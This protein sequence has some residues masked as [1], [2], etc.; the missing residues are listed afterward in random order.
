[1]F[2]VVNTMSLKTSTFSNKT[3]RSGKLGVPYVFVSYFVWLPARKL[4]WRIEKGLCCL[5]LK[6]NSWSTFFKCHY[7]TDFYMVQAIGYVLT[8]RLLL[9]YMGLDITGS[10]I[11]FTVQELKFGQSKCRLLIA[12]YGT[13]HFNYVFAFSHNCSLLPCLAALNLDTHFWNL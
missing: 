6:K 9:Y 7:F 3:L 4:F 10:F 8:K 2:W 12:N 5:R 11:T 13:A 1:L